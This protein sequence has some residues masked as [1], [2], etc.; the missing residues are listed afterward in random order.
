MKKFGKRM[1]SLLICM[2]MMT[3][4]ISGCG[5]KDAG[6]T[7]D[8]GSQTSAAGTTQAASQGRG[9]RFQRSGVPAGGACDHE[10]GPLSG[11]GER[12]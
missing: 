8:A 6:N 9:R 2:A 3:A 1:M 11:A 12:M 4:L 5:K 7:T 10:P